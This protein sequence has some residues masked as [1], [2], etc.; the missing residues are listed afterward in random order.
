MLCSI[1]ITTCHFNWKKIHNWSCPF[2][3][4]WSNC[5]I[6]YTPSSN[7]FLQADWV[8]TASLADLLTNFSSECSVSTCL[9]KKKRKEWS[10]D[11]LL[12]FWPQTHESLGKKSSRADM[13]VLGIIR[14]DGLPHCPEH[15]KAFFQALSLHIR[16]VYSG[17]CSK[18]NCRYKCLRGK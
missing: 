18:G 3:S 9:K 7:L 14:G 15:S 5:P 2:I 1:A 10:A 6:K 8:Q 13:N 4:Q 17:H 11:L 12:T 16:A